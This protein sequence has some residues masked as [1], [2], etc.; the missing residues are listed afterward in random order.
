MLQGI[1]CVCFLFSFLELLRVAGIIPKAFRHAL[2]NLLVIRYYAMSVR[3]RRLIF[4]DWTNEILGE[5]IW[6]DNYRVISRTSPKSGW[7]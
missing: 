3:I 5:T 1:F 7:N 6:I 2:C 4:R